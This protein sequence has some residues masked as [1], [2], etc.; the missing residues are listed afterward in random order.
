MNKTYLSLILPIYNE[1]DNLDELYQRSKKVLASLGNHEIIFINDGSADR[2]LEKILKFRSVDDSV[3]IIDFSRNFGHQRAI[4]AG[5]DYASGNAVVI[6]DS[7]LQDI[8]EVIPRMFEKWKAGYEIVYAKRHS[9]KDSPFKKI[10]AFLFYRTLKFF[11]EIDIP[12][13][14]GDFRLLDKRVV[15]EMR[16]LREKSR[17]MRGLVAW[18]GFKKTAVFFN[19]EKRKHGSTKYSLKK[20]IRFA[21]EGLTSFSVLPLKINYYL[22]AVILIA[23]LL[24]GLFL[25]VDNKTVT[26]FASNNLIIFLILMLAGVNFIMLGVQGEYIGK[27]HRE[28]KGRPLY[29]TRETIGFKN[30]NTN[31]S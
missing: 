8:P 15:R 2:S 24:F 31:N 22:G 21:F 30:K 19:R 6:M 29:I 14:T 18:T 7:D 23:G 13:D 4:T 20:M 9:R 27:I 12:I 10:T 11:S 3:K 1:E 26:S 16:K 17:F 5:L 25:V 28:V